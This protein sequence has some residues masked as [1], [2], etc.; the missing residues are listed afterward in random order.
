MSPER[1]RGDSN[2]ARARVAIPKKH[3]DLPPFHQP[4]YSKKSTWVGEKINLGRYT[5]RRSKATKVW[6]YGELNSPDTP[7]TAFLMPEVDPPIPGWPFDRVLFPGR[8]RTV[9]ER[10]TA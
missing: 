3:P 2:I 1:R 9:S 8:V 4:G 6:H 10:Y 7:S 5:A